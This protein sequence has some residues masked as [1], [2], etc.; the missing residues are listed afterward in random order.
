MARSGSRSADH[1]DIERFHEARAFLFAEA[2]NIDN[3][4]FD[5]WL[6]MMTEDVT[7]RIPARRTRSEGGMKEFEGR[8]HH[9]D[10]NRFMLEKRIERLDTEHAW[11]EQPRT[12]TRHF[13]SNIRVAGTEDEMHVKS[14]VLLHVN[15][16]ASAKSH[17]ISGER[18]DILRFV[19]G[20]WKLADRV[21]Y[22]DHATLP[23]G[24]ISVFI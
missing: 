19:D 14:N 22:L 2:E 1:H 6:E 21:I 24:K 15:R 9:I 4:E 16:G 13:T 5:E 7:Y 3:R 23:L 17:N 12:R 8:A 11:A 20:E 10:D 18:H